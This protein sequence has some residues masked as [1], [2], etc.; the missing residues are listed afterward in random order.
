MGLEQ[1]KKYQIQIKFGFGSIRIE[2]AHVR[3]KGDFEH[4]FYY[5]EYF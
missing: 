1:I 3:I 5:F 2:S 4:F